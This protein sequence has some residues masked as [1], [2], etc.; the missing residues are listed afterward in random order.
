MASPHEGGAAHAVPINILPVRGSRMAAKPVRQ[1]A[2]LFSN[3]A[4]FILMAVHDGT[5]RH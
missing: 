5:Q 2:T 3:V 4:R 1:N